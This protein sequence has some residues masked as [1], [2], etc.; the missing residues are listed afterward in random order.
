MRRYLATFL[1]ATALPV[2]GVLA[3]NAIVD[4]LWYGAGSPLGRNYEFNERLSKAN[5]LAARAPPGCLVL[6]SSTATFLRPS[7]FPGR[8]C[9][10]LAF[11]AG[12]VP[13]ALAYA[14]WARSLGADPTL[15]IVG[16]DVFNFAKGVEYRPEI[17]AFVS[18]L[19]RPPPRL[20]AYAS[21]DAALFSV[22]TLLGRA[23]YPK[24]YDA[25]FEVVVHD[26]AGTFDPAAVALPRFAIDPSKGAPL[27]ELRAIFPRARLVAFVPPLSAWHVE[28][29]DDAGVLDDALAATH[30][31]TAHFDEV[32]DF[33]V[34]SEV[35]AD[36]SLTYDGR[37]Y[38]T[39]VNDRLAARLQ[40]AD[41]PRFGVAVHRLE[42]A[43][44]R[45][46][47]RRALE[48]FRGAVVAADP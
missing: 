38:L 43:A 17:P 14:R 21:L 42:L 36:T 11:N 47:Y 5:Q 2:L 24:H 25:S 37:H 7:R 27:A 29:L 48:A 4:P 33:T 32:W 19:E 30:G 23:P 20:E 26:D 46:G 6:G 45:A 3:L 9:F 39:A 41:D 40:G 44:Y 1:V 34:P 22:L 8:D 31:L 28:A 13:E 35:T 12:I 10:N 18:A 15:V 16:A